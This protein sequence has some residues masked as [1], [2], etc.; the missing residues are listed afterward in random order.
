MSTSVTTRSATPT[1]VAPSSV[2]QRLR[3][4]AVRATDLADAARHL[5]SALDRFKRR[6]AAG[7]A[8]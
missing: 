4:V 5:A 2:G 3:S 8:T 6:L 7:R 1:T